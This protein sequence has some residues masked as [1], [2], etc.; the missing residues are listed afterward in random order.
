MG[1]ALREGLLCSFSVGFGSGSL[2]CFLLGTSTGEESKTVR[3]LGMC[4]KCK[5]DLNE[6][7]SR[8]GW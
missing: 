2:S 8:V 3:V 4:T 7:K 5:E 1:R 6:A